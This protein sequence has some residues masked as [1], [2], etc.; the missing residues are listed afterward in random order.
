MSPKRASSKENT[1]TGFFSFFVLPSGPIS[2]FASSSF[3]L[4]AKFF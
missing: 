2:F 1:L 4:A 3:S